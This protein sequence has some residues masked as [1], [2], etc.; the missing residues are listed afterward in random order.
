MQQIINQSQVANLGTIL[1]VWAHPDDETFCAGGLL[2]AA[3]Q[4]GQTVTCI[5]ATRGEAGSQDLE[6]WPANQLGS[7]RSKELASA[8]KVLGISN[9]HLL[10]YPDGKC[11]DVDPKE[12][13]KRIADYISKYQPNTILT[14]GPEGLTGH[15][16]HIAISGWVD[17]ALKLAETKPSVYHAVLTVNQY[18]DYLE[19]ADLKLNF[20]YNIDQPPLV[21]DNACH[22]CFCCT[23]EL[24]ACKHEALAS[25]PSQ[26]GKMFEA[27]DHDYLKEAFRIEAFVKSDSK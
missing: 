18:K 6:K 10:D 4:N 21:D 9:H 15:P 20:F 14:F 26:Y 12:A 13:S 11:A 3:S 8:L 19:A 22:I 1:T 5:T 25:M 17:A 2:A 27:F 7:V 24:C 16:D 23:E